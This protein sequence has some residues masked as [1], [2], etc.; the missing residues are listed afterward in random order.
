MRGLLS[1]GL[2]HTCT[3]T[4]ETF[5]FDCCDLLKKKAAILPAIIRVLSFGFHSHFLQ[6]FSVEFKVNA[7]SIPKFLILI[8]Q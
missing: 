1:K 7:N 2:L 5:S 3:S 8:F 4:F 6:S